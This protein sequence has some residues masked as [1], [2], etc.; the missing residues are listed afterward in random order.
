MILPHKYAFMLKTGAT[1]SEHMIFFFE[2]L[3]TKLCDWFSEEYIKSTIF[4]F[5]NASVHLSDRCKSYFKWK[6]LSVLTLPPY[7]PEQNNV[8]QVFKRLKTDLSK[9]DLSKKRLEYIVAETIIEMK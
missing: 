2:L 3:H 8:E 9:Q 4:V 7:T 6:K 5:D 1:K